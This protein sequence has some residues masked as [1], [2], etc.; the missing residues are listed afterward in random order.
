[1]N[2]IV[3]S[4]LAMAGLGVTFKIVKILADRKFE[5]VRAL[6][7]AVAE[8]SSEDLAKY[9]KA[10]NDIL[11]KNQVLAREKKALNEAVKD[12]KRN[13]G[14]DAKRNGFYA[15]ATHALDEFKASLDY[16]AKLMEIEKEMEDSITAFKKSV[17]YDDSIELLDKEIEKAIEDYKAQEKIFESAPDSISETTMKLKHAAEDAKNATV[18]A[19]KEKKDILEKQLAS[20][21]ERFAKKKRD[22][23]RS[24]EEKIAKEKRRLDDKT[25]RSVND[26]DRELD[27]AKSKMLHDIQAMR[28]EEEADCILMAND[29][30]DLVDV[31]DCNDAIRA[32][33]IAVD[34]PAAERMAW[35][36]KEHHW[37]K[38][39]V[40]FV[41]SLPLVPAG[42][43]V[44]RY[45]KFVIS[46]AKLV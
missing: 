21:Q 18:K 36:L 40:L 32:A 12:Y 31:Q 19:A 26:L 42:Y 16:D 33:D 25:M 15:D 38:G 20:E 8:N 34:T 44:Y 14:F 45:G 35:W 10:K 17:N 43:L 28:T 11:I 24:M 6:E 1:M 30:Q 39:S 4:E 5:D 2:A 37:T 9:M 46:V 29:N 7:L 3:I 23:I 27:E 41:G 13:T 22:S